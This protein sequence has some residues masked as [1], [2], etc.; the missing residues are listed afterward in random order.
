MGLFQ[1]KSHSWDCCR[2]YFTVLFH[3]EVSNDDGCGV[4]WCDKRYSRGGCIAAGHWDRVSGSNAHG[5][6]A[7]L[8][9]FTLTF[10]RLRG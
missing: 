7:A 3:G 9:G 4:G 2:L 1:S 10:F 8:L 6:G 5:A